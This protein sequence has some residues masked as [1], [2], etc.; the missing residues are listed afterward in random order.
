[1]LE[2]EI[3]ASVSQVETWERPAGEGVGRRTH[4][5]HLCDLYAGH[6]EDTMDGI[7]LSGIKIVMD[8]ANGANYELGP[9]V[10]TDLGAEVIALHCDPDGVNI[11]AGCGSL[12]PDEMIRRTV[13]EGASIGIAFDGD[14][15]RV[16]SSEF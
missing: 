8:G 4:D 11:N 10:V 13:S 9:R 3:E 12:H 14:A 6:L 15:D 1:M 16:I 7:S 5:P 2:S